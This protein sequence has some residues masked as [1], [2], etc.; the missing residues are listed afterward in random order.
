ME[1]RRQAFQ[2]DAALHM[3]P[4]KLMGYAVNAMLIIL[5]AVNCRHAV[6]QQIPKRLLIDYLNF[7][8]CWL[9][10]AIYNLSPYELVSIL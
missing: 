6:Y 5:A 3:N 1:C 9:I 2:H 10:L 7:S 4:A 8:L